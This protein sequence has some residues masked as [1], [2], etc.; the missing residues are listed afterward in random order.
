MVEEC[1]RDLDE[2]IKMYKEAKAVHNLPEWDYL[3]ENF[4]ISKAFTG[5]GGIVLRDV[6]R[7]MN[8]KIASYLHLFETFI[9]PQ[10]T[11][12]F[13]MNVLKN[14]EEKDWENVR[15][16]YKE[17]AR[18]QFKQILVDV[19][20]SEDKEAA[21]IKKIFEMWEKE[22]GE[23]SKIIEILDKKYA[24]NSLDKKKSYFG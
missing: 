21:L 24:E 2:I 7:K 13:I 17:L 9:N 5:E 12:M 19:V 20:Y 8:E 15:R 10:S 23:I 11:P 4:D 1:C 16:V 14:L 22:K 3:E 18:L 6:R